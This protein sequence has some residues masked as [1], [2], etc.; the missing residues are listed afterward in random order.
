[1]A[2]PCGTIG[3]DLR[4]DNHIHDIADWDATTRTA[5]SPTTTTASTATDPTRAPPRGVLH[6]RQPLRRHQRPHDPTAPIFLEGLV[7]GGGTP[8]AATGRSVD[9]F[10]NNMGWRVEPRRQQRRVRTLLR[11]PPSTS[12]TTPSSASATP[13]TRAPGVGYRHQPTATRPATFENNV[14]S[15]ATTGDQQN[16]PQLLHL[17]AA[18][19]TTSTPTAAPTPSCAARTSISPPSSPAGSHA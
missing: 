14:V 8:C 4:Y 7:S 1:M 15:T 17:R 12:S 13:Q 5:T 11:H 18:P 10:N 6:L 9:L 2:S 16:L 3:H 19:T